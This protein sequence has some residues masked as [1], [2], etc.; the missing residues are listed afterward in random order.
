MDCEKRAD[1]KI[2]GSAYSRYVGHDDVW[3][4]RSRTMPVAAIRIDLQYPSM[5]YQV[6]KFERRLLTLNRQHD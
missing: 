3:L 6:P 4:T 1:S 2:D 5:M